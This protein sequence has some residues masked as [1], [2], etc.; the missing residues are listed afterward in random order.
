[1]GFDPLSRFPSVTFG[2]FATNTNNCLFLLQFSHLTVLRVIQR[3]CC[4]KNSLQPVM[5]M[6]SLDKKSCFN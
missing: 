1:M 5:F 4:S 6:V 3:V 2:H